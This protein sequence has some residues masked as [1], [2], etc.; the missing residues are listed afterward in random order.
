MVHPLRVMFHCLLCPLTCAFDFLSPISQ[1]FHANFR[2]VML[3]SA[4][5]VV[6]PSEIFFLIGDS[7]VGLAYPS[8][9]GNGVLCMVILFLL[10]IFSVIVHFVG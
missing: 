3:R 5:S 2:G 7:P 1:F 4:F 8:F 6:T 10:Q 9:Q